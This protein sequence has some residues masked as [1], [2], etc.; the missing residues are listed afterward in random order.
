VPHG[1]ASLRARKQGHFKSGAAG[2]GKIRAMGAALYESRSPE[3]ELKPAATY[4]VFDAPARFIFR[5][6]SSLNYFKN[7]FKNKTNYHL[8]P[9]RIAIAAQ[10]QTQKKPRP[11]EGGAAAGLTA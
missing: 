8:F 6:K 2:H 3:R 10:V 7:S 11:G 5:Q 1:L 4:T 9:M